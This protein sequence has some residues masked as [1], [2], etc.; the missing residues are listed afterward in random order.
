MEVMTF[1][2]RSTFEPTSTYV[3]TLVLHK[4]NVIVCLWH[5]VSAFIMSFLP[6]LLAK[7]MDPDQLN[8]DLANRL[9]CPVRA[10]IYYLKLNHNVKNKTSSGVWAYG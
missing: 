9:M 5:N 6:S 2:T 4:I 3:L 1:L 10:L 8:K 7:A